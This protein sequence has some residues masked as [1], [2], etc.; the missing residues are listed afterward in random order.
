[1]ADIDKSLVSGLIRGNNDAYLAVI[2][3]LKNPVYNFAMRLC[4]DSSAAEEIT[5]ETFLAVWQGVE[6]FRWQSKFTTWVFGIA[7]RQYLIRCRKD[8]RSVET[9]PIDEQLD[10]SDR[11]DLSDMVCEQAE[12][13]RVRK[14]VY[15]LP[16]PYREVVCLVHLEG[17]TCRDAAQVLG[18]P[19][20]TIKSRTSRAL[21]FLRERL[22]ES[23]AKADE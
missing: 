1:M 15:S 19:I 23:E 4:H 18:V 22:E 7:Y 21:Q 16:D 14:A 6:S 20:G 3:A 17:F 10:T 5:Q 12:H 8:E 11:S 9:V 2:R 13:D